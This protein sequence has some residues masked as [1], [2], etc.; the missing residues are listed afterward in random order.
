MKPLTRLNGPQF[1]RLRFAT[2]CLAGAATALLCACSSADDPPPVSVATA[3]NFTVAW[4]GERRLAVLDNDTVREG[5]AALSV[6][7]APTNGRISVS[8]DGLS[9][10]PN[11]GFY[12]EDSFSYKLDVQGNGDTASSTAVVKLVVQAQ[13]VL[14][15]VVTDGPLGNANVVANVGTQTFSATADAQGRYSL[16]ISTSMASDFVMLTA[17]GSGTQSA[18]VLTSLVGEVSGLVAAASEGVVTAEAARGLMVTHLSAAQAG[19]MA[20][21]GKLPTSHAEMLL[22]AQ[23]LDGF[24]VL[25][26]AALVKLVVD[27]GVALPTAAASTRE[28]LS[29]AT[30][31][32]GFDAA[33][34]VT[35][36]AQL[37]AVREALTSDPNLALA[38]PLPGTRAQSLLFAY[39]EGGVSKPVYAV[40]LRPDGSA[41]VVWDALQP[42]QWRLDGKLVKVTFDTPRVTSGLASAS[43]GSG[44]FNQDNVTTGLTFSDLG[45]SNGR[46]T[47]ASVGRVGY[48]LNR[49]GPQ[50]GLRQDFA[51]STL[52]R[53]YETQA[54][55]LKAEDFA[56]GDRWA[57]LLSDRLP[58]PGAAGPLNFKQDVLRITAAGTGTMERKGVNVTWQ[59]T[60][61]A[62]L[63]KIGSNDYRYRRLDTGPLGEERWLVEQLDAAGLVFTMSEIMAVRASDVVIDSAGL[64]KRW[65][66]NLNDGSSRTKAFYT[67][68][69]DSTWAITSKEPGVVETAGVFT[70]T[71]RRLADGRLELVSSSPGGCNPWAGTANCQITLQRYW[72]LLAQQG[73]TLYVM[74][75]G[76][77]SATAPITSWRFVAM[78]EAAP[79]AP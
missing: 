62:L 13:L 27:A 48:T 24:A 20:Q 76:P 6:A 26:A 7:T 1:R 39:G 54:A 34:R 56:S 75:T 52:I 33:R 28:L 32:N 19:L 60:E 74:E 79:P 49:S 43:D 12:G 53:R 16:P 50:S 45:A 69:G 40:T 73:K 78:T 5:S 9:Y 42:S 72:T 65:A 22:A 14:R 37:A 70:R 46:Y 51:F 18:V 35:D 61:G 31:L 38:P 4:N 11:P 77:G 59:V 58:E 25:D 15:G 64:A 8:S 29:S 55:P 67:L 41:S 57:G 63:V 36:A 10:T 47:L 23:K 71:W 68:K 21:A 3:D 30:L 44:Q 17:T 66:G 2:G